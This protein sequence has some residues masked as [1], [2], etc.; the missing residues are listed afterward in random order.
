[1]HRLL[2]ATFVSLVNVASLSSTMVES[3]LKRAWV[4]NS[5]GSKIGA[6]GSCL[7]GVSLSEVPIE[8]FQ[9]PTMVTLPSSGSETE[10][11][12][13]QREDEYYREIYFKP[14]PK[15]K[16]RCCSSVVSSNGVRLV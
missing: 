11:E 10:S 13:R 4:P 14:T 16:V 9:L 5:I 12:C 15:Y 3:V 6:R 7:G 8:L 1:M 2:L